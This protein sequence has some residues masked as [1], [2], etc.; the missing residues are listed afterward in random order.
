MPQHRDTCPPLAQ[1][2]CPPPRRQE[3]QRVFITPFF[4]A[5]VC[6]IQMRYSAILI[7]AASVACVAALPVRAPPGAGIC[8]NFTY[9]KEKTQATLDTKRYAGVWFEQ[10]RSKNF[11][12]DHNC[13]CTTANYT[14]EDGYIGVANR[15]RKGSVSGD[16]T[17]PTHGKATCPDPKCDQPPSPPLTL[18]KIRNLLQVPGLPRSGIFVVF[19]QRR[20]RN[21]VHRL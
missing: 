3:Y 4:H 20:L 5:S 16:L 11:I 6:L 10:G 13:F 7:F 14:L 21:C 17:G 8:S 2:I 18:R 12:F 19:P 15:C 9:A 1:R